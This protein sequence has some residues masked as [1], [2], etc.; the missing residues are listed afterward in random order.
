MAT[1]QSGGY[2]LAY[3][4]ISG[5]DR[6]TVVLVHGFATNREENWKR[7]GWLTALERKGYRAVALDLR[8]HGQSDKPHD[9]AAYARDAM[10]GDVLALMDHLELGR[11]DLLGYS[12]GSHISL[13]VALKAPDRVANLILGSVGGRMLP[14]APQPPAPAMTMAE[15]M[16][17]EDPS[18]IT[19]KTMRGFR[20]FADNQ[21]DDRLALAACSQ[22]AVQPLDPDDLYGLRMPVL[23]VAG[24]R[25][26]IAG[27]PQA[28]A[29][30]IPGAKAVS[31]PGVDHF[32]AIPHALFKASVF[33]F[34]EGWLD[35]D[36]PAFE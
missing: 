3:D 34:L 22:G 15:A 11:V 24:V 8:G 1:F 35:D 4:D 32:S 5:G 29:D 10:V 27:D 13:R 9:A 7:L 20:Q 19:D 16:T 12:M 25:D 18:T 2:T 31:L 14:G 21:G 23:V 17:A 30:A 6:G 33:D 28:Q 26:E 36:M